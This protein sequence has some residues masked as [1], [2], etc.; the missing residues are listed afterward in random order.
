[1]AKVKPKWLSSLPKPTR[2]RWSKLNKRLRISEL[3]NKMLRATNRSLR[4]DN[5]AMQ[6][7][8]CC[9]AEEMLDIV[10]ELRIEVGN[11]QLVLGQCRG[12]QRRGRSGTGEV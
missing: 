9:R 10:D 5:I 3:Q 8:L 1:M 4:Q 7:W 11:V 12:E 2:V 6:S